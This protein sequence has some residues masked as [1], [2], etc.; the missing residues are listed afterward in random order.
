MILLL[1]HFPFLYRHDDSINITT[2]RKKVKN[3]LFEIL[4]L[5]FF[6]HFQFCLG[7]PVKYPSSREYI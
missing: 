3:H 6:K 2:I 4:G 7:H 5:L 1:Q